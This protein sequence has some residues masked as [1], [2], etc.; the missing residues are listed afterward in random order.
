M[1][2]WLRKCVHKV[3]VAVGFHVGVLCF[4]EI[5]LFDPDKHGALK[6]VFQL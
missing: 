4:Y 6:V 2:V 5:V 1:V 3:V